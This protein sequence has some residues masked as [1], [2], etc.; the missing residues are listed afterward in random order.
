MSAEDREM[1]NILARENRRDRFQA[2]MNFIKPSVSSILDLGCGIGSLTLLLTERFP[3][4]SIVGLEESK[5]LLDELNSKMKTNILVVRA[6][7]PIFPLSPSPSTLWLLSKYYTR[8][9]ISKE[10]ES[11]W[12]R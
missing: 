10:N 5:Y 6:D 4:A 8:F 11:Y 3:S 1:A 7:A 12:Q 2:V 9:S